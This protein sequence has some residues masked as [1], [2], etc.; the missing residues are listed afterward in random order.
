MRS[1][2]TCLA[3]TWVGCYLSH[4]AP[5]D[6][7][8]DAPCAIEREPV[9]VGPFRTRFEAWRGPGNYGGLSWSAGGDAL[10]VTT[11]DSSLVVLRPAS[12]AVA[13]RAPLPILVVPP[14]PVWSGDG[15]FVAVNSGVDRITVYELA[16]GLRATG[17]VRLPT[18]RAASSSVLAAFATVGLIVRENSDPTWSL[19]SF[20]ME[21]RE[22]LDLA[23]RCRAI[24]ARIGCRTTCPSRTTD[25]LWRLV[26]RGTSGISLDVSTCFL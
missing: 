13:E 22:V 21:S 20:S 14:Q 3:L 15:R 12:C 10:A 11:Y 4:P 16:G 26:A 23:A 17:P 5:R 8:A 18:L 1:A 2:A 6:A 9:G 25:A 24:P 19:V 7:P